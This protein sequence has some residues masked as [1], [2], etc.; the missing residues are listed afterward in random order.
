[1]ETVPAM[2]GS[3]TTFIEINLHQESDV[4]GD[5]ETVPAMTG[6]ST[7]FIQIN[8]HH[9]KNALAVLARNMAVMQTG[10]A[11]RCY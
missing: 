3:S 4:K 5:M 8:L 1:M 11:T 2:T 10:I 7:T 9:T 6:S